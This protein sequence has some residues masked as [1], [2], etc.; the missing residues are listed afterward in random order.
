[1]YSETTSNELYFSSQNPKTNFLE[2][3]FVFCTKRPILPKWPILADFRGEK[4]KNHHM[5]DYRHMD[6][7]SR[8]ECDPQIDSAQLEIQKST[9]KRSNWGEKLTFQR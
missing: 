4:I 9:F 3:F 6:M 8:T 2:P 5:G 7:F 1:M